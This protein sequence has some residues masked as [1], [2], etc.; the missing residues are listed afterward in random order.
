MSQITKAYNNFLKFEKE[1]KTSNSKPSSENSS[2]GLLS[3]RNPS[4]KK[5]GE[6]VT[7]LDK[8]AEYVQR[9]RKHRNM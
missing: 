6:K 7:E 5:S 9:I 1:K 2:T 3:R 4:S 8:V